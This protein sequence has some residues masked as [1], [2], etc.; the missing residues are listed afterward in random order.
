MRLSSRA[1]YRERSERQW[2]RHRVED[3]QQLCDITSCLLSIQFPN[4]ERTDLDLKRCSGTNVTEFCFES[5]LLSL[6]T[7]VL[8]YLN[9]GKQTGRGIL[10]SYNHVSVEAHSRDLYSVFVIWWKLP[11][12][13]G[14][15]VCIH[16]F[17]S[18]LKAVRYEACLKV[19]RFKLGRVSSFVF[20]SRIK[21]MY[22]VNVSEPFIMCCS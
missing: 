20:N 3:L 21:K 12:E 1:A 6:L 10:G 4:T 13:E 7:W 9:D 22:Q 15:V 17:K 8:V 2:R 19:L 14:L 18:F 16:V 5:E 11:V